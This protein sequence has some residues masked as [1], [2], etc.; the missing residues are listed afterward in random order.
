MQ[1]CFCTGYVVNVSDTGSFAFRCRF[2][3]RGRHSVESINMRPL[4]PLRSIPNLNCI[5]Y[6]DQIRVRKTR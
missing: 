4:M 3:Q 1:K 6:A 5:I 2:L